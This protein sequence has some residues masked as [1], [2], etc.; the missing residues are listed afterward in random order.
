VT[1]KHFKAIAEIL[2]I[3]RLNA[4]NG[5]DS[6]SVLYIEELADDLATYFKSQNH[7][8]DRARFLQAA[9]IGE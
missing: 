3:H 1:K 2:R 7:R 9:G 5:Y 6:I 4:Q 8:F